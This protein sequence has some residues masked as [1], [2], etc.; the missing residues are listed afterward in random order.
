MNGQHTTEY[1]VQMLATRRADAPSEV[2]RADPFKLDVWLNDKGRIV[3]T[4]SKQIVTVGSIKFTSTT[5]VNL[6]HFGESVHIVAP[7]DVTPQ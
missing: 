6:S 5:L 7:V 4:E 2:F 1:A 3:R